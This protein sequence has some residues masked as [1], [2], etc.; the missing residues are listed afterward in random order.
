MGCVLVS[1]LKLRAGRERE[2]ER[3]QENKATTRPPFGVSTFFSSSLDRFLGSCI[4]SSPLQKNVY[5]AVTIPISALIQ[6]L[7]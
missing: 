2:R 5:A 1:V 3:E 7:L 4:Q 6:T